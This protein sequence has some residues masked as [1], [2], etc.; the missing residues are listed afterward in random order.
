[1]SSKTFAK[2]SKKNMN[3]RVSQKTKNNSKNSRKK[4]KKKL[5]QIIL[6]LLLILLVS[7]VLIFFYFN[8]QFSKVNHI[9]ISKTNNDLGIKQEVVDNLKDKDID[10]KS[11]TN[12]ALFG[13]DARN[14]NDTARS[15][16]IMIGTID[17]A[18]KKLKITSIM[19]D[20]YVNIEGHGKDKITNA[21]GIGG[22]QLA[23]KTLN[24]NFD[25]NIRNFLTVN[26]YGMEDVIDYLG[27]VTIDVK[28]QEITTINHYIKELCTI[29]KKKY[30]PI[31]KS[32]LQVLNG[33]QS[34]NYARIRSVG[35]S[36]FERT[37]RQRKVLNEVFQKVMS[38]GKLKYPEIVS[39]FLPLIST[40]ISNTE[41][42]TIGTKFFSSGIKKMEQARFPL[43]GFCV[44]KTIKGISYLV[45]RM[46]TTKEQLHK[47]IFDDI[48]ISEQTTIKQN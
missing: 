3:D 14:P 27:G 30:T 44:D 35:N 33:R 12:F 16:S 43:D 17:Y 24:Q 15:D 39:K 40:S 42:F 47:Y 8:N 31:T 6:V 20:S 13:L 9:N 48:P 5:V 1:M 21:Y 34:V 19:R 7:F 23:L 46:P 18:H 29:D 36:D 38:A 26:F 32:G 37:Q 22:P 4:R 28:K 11:I 45:P 10:D 41:I 2:N 25:L